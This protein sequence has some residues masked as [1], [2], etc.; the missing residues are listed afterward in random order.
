M[1]RIS[2]APD[3]WVPEDFIYKSGSEC[4]EAHPEQAATG[5]WDSGWQTKA[6]K[7]AKALEKIAWKRNP[8]P[9]TIEAAQELAM[10]AIEEYRG[11]E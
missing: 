1:R 8:M 7:L 9:C 10:N 4:L 3:F 6:D 2:D 11:E 5:V